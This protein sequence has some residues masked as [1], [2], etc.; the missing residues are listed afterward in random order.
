MPISSRQRLA[1]RSASSAVTS[2]IPIKVPPATHPS[3]ALLLLNSFA[4][5]ALF[6]GD[7]ARCSPSRLR[8]SPDLASNSC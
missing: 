6:L 1:E 5:L 2:L 8:S 7:A 3:L 4:V